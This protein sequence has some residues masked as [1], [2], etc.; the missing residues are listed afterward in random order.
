MYVIYKVENL[1]NGKIYIGQTNN[2]LRRKKEHLGLFKSDDCIFHRALKKNGFDNFKWEIIHEQKHKDGMAELEKKFIKEYN[3]YYRNVNTK[4]YNMTTGGDG[5]CGWNMRPTL[6]LD[7]KGNILKEFI[8]AKDCAN[9]LKIEDSRLVNDKCIKHNVHEEKFVLYYKDDFLKYGFKIKEKEWNTLP[10]VQLD[11]KGNFIKEFK[12]IS[13]ASIESGGNRTGIIGCLK[14]YYK[15]SKNF[16]WVYKDDYNKYTD[17]TV[18]KK[19]KQNKVIKLDLDNKIVGM[20]YN[21]ADAIRDLGKGSHKGIFK[22]LN[23]STRTY[24]GF[25]WQKLDYFM[26]VNTEISAE[27]KEFAQS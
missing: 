11:L 5:G 4:G 24:Y 2:M 21:S 17:Y 20:F 23:S 19:G 1:I 10:I 22:V 12:S 26:Q 16:I 15:S 14:G 18:I 8:S 25:K 3:S 13:E 9:F 6:L 7:L 27:I